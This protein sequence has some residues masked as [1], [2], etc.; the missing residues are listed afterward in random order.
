M[1]AGESFSLCRHQ[2]L[3]KMLLKLTF[4][5]KKKISECVD[6]YDRVV[7]KYSTNTVAFSFVVTVKIIG[8]AHETLFTV[9]W[10]LSKS[11]T[12]W[13]KLSQPDTSQMGNAVQTLST[14][15]PF[16]IFLNS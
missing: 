16:S 9:A 8:K 10:Y 2:S 13:K 15:K 11:Y 4:Q 14:S 3:I 6:K 1:N 12:F 7:A 5:R